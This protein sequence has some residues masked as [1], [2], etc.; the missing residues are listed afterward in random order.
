MSF[1]GHNLTQNN[2]LE[3]GGEERREGVL[4]RLTTRPV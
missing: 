1:M 2:D 3:Q 4:G